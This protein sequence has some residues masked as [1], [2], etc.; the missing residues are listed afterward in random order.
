MG[1]KST[2]SSKSYR[3]FFSRT[4]VSGGGGGSGFVGGDGQAPSAFPGFI[5][6]DYPPAATTTTSGDYRT[7]VYD[8]NGYFNITQLDPGGVNDSFEYLIVAGGGGGY[9]QKDTGTSGGGAGGGAGGYRTGTSPIPSTLNLAITIGGGGSGNTP[10]TTA[11]PGNPSSIISPGSE[12]SIESAGGGRAYD[13]DPTGSS[14]QAPGD[15][16]VT[17]TSPSAD[18]AWGHGRGGSGGGY[19]NR[20]DYQPTNPLVSPTNPTSYPGNS[21]PTMYFNSNRVAGNIPPVSPPQGNP[22]ALY[23]H[24]NNLFT[25]STPIVNGSPS[26]FTLTTGTGGGGAGKAAGDPTNT[27]VPSIPSV[28]R[29][30]WNQPPSPSGPA[31][32]P[33]NPTGLHPTQSYAY[34]IQNQ[35]VG[36]DGQYS[37]LSPPTFGST[38]P[39]ISP[40]LRYFAGGGAGAYSD[41]VKNPGSYNPVPTP[42]APV[43]D[44]D[45]AAPVAPNYYYW[46]Q[47]TSQYQPMLIAFRDYP[48]NPV[49]GAGGGG[50]WF[51]D[52]VTNT[53]GGGGGGS[54]S[55]TAP[56]LQTSAPIIGV[57][58]PSS[59]PGNS[60]GSGIVIIKYKY[61]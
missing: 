52:G 41:L 34:Q 12:I 23:F 53:G 39:Q 7:I 56:N 8:A 43:P 49:G 24:F 18:P 11:S 44:P 4:F 30:S 28:L 5:V 60:G 22:G 17:P 55:R 57:M 46:W 47:F 21:A 27:I 19:I 14:S 10:T 48:P 33:A 9:L 38:P 35:F 16:R 50:N 15:S 1:F 2:V 20:G 25:P 54:N 13:V 40:S 6:A 45:I 42:T 51:S 36:G 31:P 61:Q 37:P 59:P 3:D 26:G 32:A 58:S 29:G